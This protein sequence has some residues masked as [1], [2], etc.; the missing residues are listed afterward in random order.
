MLW[1]WRAGDHG[2]NRV[3]DTDHRGARIRDYFQR[4]HGRDAALAPNGIDKAIFTEV[5]DVISPRSPGRLRVLAE[6]HWTRLSKTFLRPKEHRN[7][8]GQSDQVRHAGRGFHIALC[9][10]EDDREAPDFIKVVEIGLV[11]RRSCTRIV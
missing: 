10:I 2:G 9:W 7:V 6:G 4:L 11:E 1:S 8:R 5:G 3:Q